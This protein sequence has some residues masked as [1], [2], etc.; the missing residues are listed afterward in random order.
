VPFS[1]EVSI[2]G[3]RDAKGNIR[4]YPPSLNLHVN[5]ILKASI[6]NTH[7]PERVITQAENKL[8]T[9]MNGL[10][11]VGVM[12]MECFVVDYQLVVNELAPRVHNSGHWTQAGSSI[13]QFESHIRAVTGL[14]IGKPAYNG[15]TLMLNLIGTELNPSWFEIEGA[16][17]TWYG[18]EVREGRKLGHINICSPSD[19]TLQKG[20]SKA[21]NVSRTKDGKQISGVN[22][23]CCARRR[24]TTRYR[25]P[26][27]LGITRRFTTF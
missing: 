10:K 25:Q 8:S 26:T 9:V 19:E 21:I 18:K 6:A 1:D 22:T 12:A 3:C 4:F 7:L 23:D 15:P 14:P 27:A 13:C 24:E 17:I 11:Y 16:E 20:L 2:I 5:G